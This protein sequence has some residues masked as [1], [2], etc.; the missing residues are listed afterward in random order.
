M[1]VN[2]ATAS[3]TVLKRS[4]ERTDLRWCAMRE[5][6]VDHPKALRHLF[7][8]IAGPPSAPG[9]LSAAS[10]FLDES[11][12]GIW[13][14]VRCS[15]A[16]RRPAIECS[17]ADKLI[18]CTLADSGVGALKRSLGWQH[19]AFTCPAELHDPSLQSEFAGLEPRQLFAEPF[20]DPVNGRGSRPFHPPRGAEV[21]CAP[22][23]GIFRDP[24]TRCFRSPRPRTYPPAALAGLCILTRQASHRDGRQPSITASVC[25]VRPCAGVR[26]AAWQPLQLVCR[27]AAERP[28]PR[29]GGTSTCLPEHD[30]DSSPIASVYK[31][32]FAF[33]AHLSSA[34]S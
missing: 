34:A 10:I 33:I 18:Y 24:L 31:A 25:A 16:D 21:P 32:P 13:I 9:F 8:S 12:A 28:V 30:G 15:V 19:Q 6:G 22:A 23:A 11:S 26:I 3:A 14:A 27:P 2:G 7:G 4:A 1:A 20:A 17:P 29:F 5:V